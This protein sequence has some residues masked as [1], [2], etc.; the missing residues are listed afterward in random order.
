MTWKCFVTIEVSAST[1]SIGCPWKGGVGEL[2]RHLG[3][4]VFQ[5]ENL[6]EFM[7]EIIKR[8][9]SKDSKLALDDDEDS[10]Q[11]STNEFIN[12]NT[13]GS[14]KAR[15]FQK[16]KKLMENVFEEKREHPAERDSIVSLLDKSCN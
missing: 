8:E 12:F 15:L 7:K 16:N 2:E 13:K 11:G 4:C 10:N 14:L 5:N 6:P 3:D 1:L 9:S